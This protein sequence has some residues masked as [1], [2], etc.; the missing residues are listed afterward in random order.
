M[1]VSVATRGGGGLEFPIDFLILVCE[2]VAN[3]TVEQSVNKI[4]FRID[5][6][7]Q[8]FFCGGMYSDSP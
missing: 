6:K 3:R 7:T 8:S 2:N 4:T 1:Y 5:L